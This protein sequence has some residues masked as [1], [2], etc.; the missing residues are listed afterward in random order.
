MIHDQGTYRI[1]RK[2]ALIDAP[3]I[4]RNNE[5]INTARAHMSGVGPRVIDCLP[6]ENVLLI[7]WI[8]AKTLHA[9]DFE[10]MIRY[11]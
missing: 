3:I 9:A 7:E 6:E 11:W 2:R 5:R 1:A 10:I 8:E 4:D